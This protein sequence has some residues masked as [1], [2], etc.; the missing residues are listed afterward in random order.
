MAHSAAAT[1]PALSPIVAGAAASAGTAPAR[2]VCDIDGCGKTYSKQARLLEHQRVHT[3]EVRQHETNLTP[4]ALCLR[5]VRHIVYAVHTFGSTHAIP[6][7]RV[8]ETLYM[9]LPRLQQAFLD[10]SAPAP[11]RS[12]VPCQ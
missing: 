2:W 5:R 1:A 4:A 11:T 9:Q 10:T 6:Y 7:G 8:T 12:L 3:G